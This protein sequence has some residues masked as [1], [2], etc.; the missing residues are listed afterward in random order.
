MIHDDPP[1]PKNLQEAIDEVLQNVPR[2]TELH[3]RIMPLDPD[4]PNE[5][6]CPSPSP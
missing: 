3:L 4:E 6:Q 1:G 5:R 2:G